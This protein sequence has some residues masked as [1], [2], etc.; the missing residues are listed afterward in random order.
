MIIS[1]VFFTIGHAQEATP[2]RIESGQAPEFQISFTDDMMVNGTSVISF[3]V[4]PTTVNVMTILKAAYSTI[5]L[6]F[7]R[8]ICTESHLPRREST[9]REIRYSSSKM[10]G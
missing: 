2:I 3:T 4:R 1:M 6:L 10:P 7:E 9:R 8:G 5:K